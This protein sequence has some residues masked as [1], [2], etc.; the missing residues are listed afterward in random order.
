MQPGSVLAQKRRFHITPTLT[1]VIGTFVAVTAALV[2]LVQVA[3]SE[4][5]VRSLGGELINVGMD[6]LEQAFSEQIKAIEEAGAY[7]EAALNSGAV[8]I[9]KPQETEEYLFGM[10]SAMEH[11]SFVIIADKDG[12]SLQVDRGSGDGVLVPNFVPARQKDPALARLIDASARQTEAFWTEPQF[13]NARQHTYVTHVQPVHDRGVFEGVIITAMSMHGLSEI[14]ADISTELVTVFMIHPDGG[15][16]VAHPRLPDVFDRLTTVSPLVDLEHSPDAFLATL[17]E[18][19][20]VRASRYGIDEGHELRVGYDADQQKR[21]IILE[22]GEHA[23]ESLPVTIGA[24]FPAEI[25][26]QPLDQ[27]SNSILI[28]MALLGVSLIGAGLL[29]HRISLPIRR[30]AHGARAV[31]ELDLEN[32]QELPPSRVRELDD[33][34]SGFNSMVAGLNAFRRYVPRALVLELLKEGRA[35]APPEEREVAVLFT[36]IAGFTSASEG[37]SA[38]DTAEF[39]NHHLSLL[40]HEIRSRGGTIDKYIGDSV[41]AFFGAPHRLENPAELA[42]QAAIGMDVAIRADNAERAKRGLAPVRVRIGL[43]VGP[44]IVGDIGAPDRVNY[45]VIGDTVNVAARLESLGTE[46]DDKAE[47]IILVSKAVADLLSSD[48]KLQPVGKHKV[49][50]KQNEIEVVRLVP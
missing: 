18:T 21:F 3:T 43:H 11:V 44:L 29:A 45:T 36:D 37:M 12:N 49:K 14:T 5:V 38:R 47:V 33:L 39:V 7:T 32:T 8:L 42:A 40:G 15:K 35:H 50:G 28:G 16:L 1:T 23:P 22:K 25:L 34:A 30:V 19:K 6:A 26:E 24:H 31:A 41:M 13:H 27:L 46:I 17:Q 9:S 10:L 4:K 2:L 48:F 20:R